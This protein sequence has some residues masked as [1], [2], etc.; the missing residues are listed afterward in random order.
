[1]DVFPPYIYRV[2]QGDCRIRRDDLDIN[3]HSPGGCTLVRHHGPGNVFCV[4]MNKGNSYDLWD[5]LRLFEVLV[6]EHLESAVGY[7]YARHLDAVGRLV[8]LE[9]GGDDAGQGEG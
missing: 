4:F 8:V 5:E 1:M 3:Q 2:S 9:D 6:V 7:E